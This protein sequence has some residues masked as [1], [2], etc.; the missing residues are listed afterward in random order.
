M[1]EKDRYKIK[2][3]ITFSS[4]ADVVDFNRHLMLDYSKNIDSLQ[5]ALGPDTTLLLRTAPV[6]MKSLDDGFVNLLETNAAIR[7]LGAAMHVGVIDWA[8]MVQVRKALQA[9]V[10]PDCFPAPRDS[11]LCI[12]VVFA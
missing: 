9:S 12:L 11:P 6:S 5:F 2:P 4:H 1:F 8:T 7:L 10:D 3:Q